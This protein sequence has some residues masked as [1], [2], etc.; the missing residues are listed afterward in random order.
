LYILFSAAKLPQ[1]IE[2]PAC[3]AIVFADSSIW[4]LANHHIRQKPLP[5]AGHVGRRQ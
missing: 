3:F 4:C 5:I 1:I 2:T